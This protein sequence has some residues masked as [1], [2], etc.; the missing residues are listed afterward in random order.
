MA[1]I[2]RL[3]AILSILTLAI[4]PTVVTATT[5]NYT[6][7]GTYYWIAPANI[8]KLYLSI[9]GGGGSGASTG[10]VSAYLTSG[11]GGA[12]GSYGNHSYVTV[13]PGTN[14]TLIVGAG[15]AQAEPTWGTSHFYSVVSNPGGSSVAFGYTA[16]GGAGGAVGCGAYGAYVYC[17]GGP[18]TS[19]NFMTL[20]SASSGGNSN[21]YT[22]GVG[23]TGYGSGGG[24]AA[25]NGTGIDLA[26][27]GS[28][29]GGAGKAGYIGITD[30]N[31]SEGN[32]PDFSASPRTGSGGTL[33]SFTNI[34]IIN[35]PANLTFLWDFGDGGTSNT[36]GNVNHVYSY[37]GIY[38]VSLNITS[39][40]GTTTETKKDYITISATDYYDPNAPPKSVRFHIQTIWGKALPGAT[41]S[42]IGMGTSTGNWDWVE[43]LLSIPLSTVGINTTPMVDTTDSNG[44]IVFLMVPSVKYNITTTLTGYTFP[45]F[46]VTPQDTQY[47]IVADLNGTGWWGPS[48]NNTLE[49]YN[50]SVT[51][52][53][54]TDTVG[55]IIINF[56]DVSGSTIGGNI[57]IA[58]DNTTV[59]GG[60]DEV[61]VIIPITSSSMNESQNVTVPQEGSAY[62]VFVNPYGAEG[63]D[64]K[65]IRSFAVWFKGHPI[66]FAGFSP[67]ILLWFSMFLIIFLAMFA[68]ATH[69]PQMAIILCIT[70]WVLYGMGWLDPIE[71]NL[72]VGTPVLVFTL[73]FATVMAIW[74]NLREGKRKETGR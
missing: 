37:T 71:T 17:N 5:W 43:T 2:L 66:T 67:T 50:I 6:T 41:V 57:T 59:R 68:G 31:S 24:G 36:T 14:Y 19:T 16:P 13:V 18:G 55:Q 7:P 63:P 3:L 40:Y 8:T 34:S 45:P 52:T 47:N 61:I 12:A 60:P 23:G 32:W 22:G 42:A 65:A 53:K 35:T 1:R 70:S 10:R 15:G 30:I 44:N 48:G 51:S 11:L 49:Q 54:L 26:Y 72:W 62:K 38:T 69:A 58:Q 73:G 56:T 20:T 25:G 74:W 4:I 46:Y 28:T 27:V 39:D 33:V 9:A 29:Y 64:I 21:P